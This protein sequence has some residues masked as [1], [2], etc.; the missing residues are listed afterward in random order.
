MANKQGNTTLIFM[1]I[2][3]YL[4][5]WL[6]ANDYGHVNIFETYPNVSKPDF[7]NKLPGI[8]IGVFGDSEGSSF[9][10]GNEMEEYSRPIT[11]DIFTVSTLNNQCSDLV[12]LIKNLF[13]KN[14]IFD[15]IDYNLATPIAISKF[16]IV[17]TRSTIFE[18]APTIYNHG[19]VTFKVVLVE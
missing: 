16:K 18:T 10:L 6:T 13:K 3:H 15:F 19:I 9:E 8:S 11:I 1:N 2:H 5:N 12:D 4:T 14:L 17:N 7:V